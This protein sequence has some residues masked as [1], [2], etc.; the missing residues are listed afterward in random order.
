MMERTGKTMGEEIQNQVQGTDGAAGLA[1]LLAS[2]ETNAASAAQPAGGTSVNGDGQTAATP[3][4]L[5]AE[6]ADARFE[7]M[8]AEREAGL[9]ETAKRTAQSITDSAMAKANQRQQEALDGVN[10]QISAIVAEGGSVPEKVQ[11][12]WRENAVKQAREETR[13]VSTEELGDANSSNEMTAQEPKTPAAAAPA[14]QSV[15][16]PDFLDRKATTL[17]AQYGVTLTKDDPEFEGLDLSKMKSDPF[18]FVV[19]YEGKLKAKAQRLQVN[20]GT[21]PGV[22]AVGGPVSPQTQ[23]ASKSPL[24]KITM[25][26]QPKT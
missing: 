8:W 24:E 4:Y 16:V 22:T 1:A 11:A 18:A 14:N 15:E 17:E 13:N 25:G 10:A 5:T 21:V 2:Q 23:W 26:Y 9:K 3:T 20:H 6:E 19:D 12:Q 7:K